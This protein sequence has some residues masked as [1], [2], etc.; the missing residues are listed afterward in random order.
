MEK[1]LE[2]AHKYGIKVLFNSV[3]MP[4]TVNEEDK[5]LLETVQ[6]LS[7]RDVYSAMRL[8]GTQRNETVHVVPDSLWNLDD[9]YKEI[10]FPDR[11]IVKK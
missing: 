11:N 3:G 10:K 6:Y 8:C 7:V 1:P 2:Y 5:N 9:Y 4:D